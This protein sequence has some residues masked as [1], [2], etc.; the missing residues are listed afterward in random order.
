MQQMFFALPADQVTGLSIQASTGLPQTVQ[1]PVTV[2][3]G[4]VGDY[5]PTNYDVFY[6]SN[7]IAEAGSETYT[8]SWTTN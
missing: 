8:L 7:A 2:Q 3:V 4:G 1:G 6:V 5:S